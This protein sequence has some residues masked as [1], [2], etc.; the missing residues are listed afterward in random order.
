M[1]KHWKTFIL[2]ILHEFLDIPK[3][4]QMLLR[5]EYEKVFLMPYEAEFGVFY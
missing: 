2:I 4:N 3:K 1:L 5:E